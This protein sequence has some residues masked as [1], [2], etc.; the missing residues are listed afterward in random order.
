MVGSVRVVV[1]DVETVEDCEVD[2]RGRAYV[3]NEAAGFIVGANPR[4]L[5]PT[6]TFCLI[7]SVVTFSLLDQNRPS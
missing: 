3:A 4:L 1:M 6:H 7:R 5:S 2:E